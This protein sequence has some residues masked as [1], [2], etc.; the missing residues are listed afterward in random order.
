M[1]ISHYTGNLLNQLN[2]DDENG[3]EFVNINT[4][5]V[6]HIRMKITKVTYISRCMSTNIDE[7]LLYQQF[8]SSLCYPVI[9]QAHS[10]AN[11]KQRY[12][13]QGVAIGNSPSEC[14]VDIYNAQCTVIS[15]NF[16]SSTKLNIS[17]FDLALRLCAFKFFIMQGWLTYKEICK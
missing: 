16:T 2:N 14:H 15:H 3:S 9:V 8:Q 6:R 1:N 17:K 13:D 5:H 11:Y 7:T 4:I 10:L 12:S